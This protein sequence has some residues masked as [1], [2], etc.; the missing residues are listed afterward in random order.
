M[1]W[2]NFHD[3]A[4]SAFFFIILTLFLFTI[5]MVISFV[6]SS[7]RDQGYDNR[8]KAEATTLRI[9]VIDPKNNS[10][11]YFNRSDLKNK[12]VIDMNTFYSHFHDN[13][14]DKIKSWIFDIC[15]D[16]RNADHYIEADVLVNHGRNT[17]FSLLKLLKYD[18]NE[19]LI[20]LESFI[21][22]YI[23]PNN[24]AA[25]KKTKKAIFTGVVKRSTMESLILKEKS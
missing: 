4:F 20:H 5:A 22:K 13:D 10:A 18:P 6:M 11:T 21:L 23:T 7:K 14:V 8:I 16:Y 1:K 2:F 17:Y 15:T 3:P 12:K 19:G 9:Y 24:S 25:K